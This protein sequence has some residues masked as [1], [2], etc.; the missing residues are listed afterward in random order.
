MVHPF[1][2]VTPGR[3]VVPPPIQQSSSIR[4]AC[5]NSTNLMR[6]STLVSWPAVYML[7][8][9]PIWTRSPMMTKLVSRMVKLQGSVTVS[10][11]Y[12]ASLVRELGVL[13]LEVHEAVLSNDN[14]ASVVGSE[15]R[16]D[17]SA[18][19]YTAQECLE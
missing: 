18:C 6:D 11:G 7:T 12:R 15:W 2:I 13:S 4:M 17:E 19:A 9:G 16:L 10:L 1:P 3:I 14:I 5:P 8:L